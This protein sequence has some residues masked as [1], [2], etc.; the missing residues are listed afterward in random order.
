[1]RY[2]KQEILIGKDAQRK[3]ENSKVS[4][5][6]IGATG[7]AVLEILARAGIGNIKIIDRDVVELEN[8]HRQK[9]FTEE[10]INKPKAMAAKERILQI[11]SGINVESFVT[12]LDF[13]NIS[14]LDGSDLMLDCTD[15]IYARFLLNDFSR[16]CN[17]PWIYASVIGTKG[18]VMNITPETQCFSCIFKEPDSPLDTCDTAGILNTAP[19][20][21][22]AVQ[23]TEAVKILTGYEY[24]RDLISYD[25][26]ANQLDKIKVKKKDNCRACSGIYDYLNG[27]KARKTIKICGSCSFQIK[28]ENTDMEMLFYKLAKLN[29]VSAGDECLVFRDIILFKS[30]RALVKA[31]SKEK[32]KITLDRYMG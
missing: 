31:D 11:N 7:T 28:L 16:K 15:N 29:P 17:I 3:L 27:M 32:A 8:L 20:A 26:W 14:I 1:M 22:S 30:G 12:D 18:M 4:I 2:S 5:I 9:L 13:D 6:G 21:V 23:A 24:C 25:L 10:D 19:Q